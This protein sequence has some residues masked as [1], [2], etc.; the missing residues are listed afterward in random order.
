[1]QNDELEFSTTKS[2]CTAS[3]DK[4]GLAIQTR[5]EKYSIPYHRR[6]K[7]LGAGL[8]A[9]TRRNN[10]ILKAR[11][12]AFRART[13]RFQRLK[14]AKVDTARL[15]RTG[16]CASMTFGQSIMGVATSHLL[17]Q[18]RAAAAAAATTHG[19]CGQNLD[20]ALLL[21]DGS[22][23]GKADPAYA[24]HSGPIG[25]WAMA[26]W[27][28]RLPADAL[29][30]LVAKAK[31]RLGKAKNPWAV[32]TGPGA[33]FIAT[34]ARLE[35]SVQGAFNIV[36]DTGVHLSLRTT[37][38]VVVSRHCDEAVRIWRWRRV[39]AVLPG[40]DLQG[41]VDFSPIWKLL[42][43]NSRNSQWTQDHQAMLASA[44][45]GRQ[46][47]QT[48]CYA[49]GFTEHNRCMLC[50]YSQ[51]AERNCSIEDAIPHSP[52]GNLTHRIWQCSTTKPIRDLQAPQDTLALIHAGRHSHNLVRY[53]RAIFPSLAYTI[54][55]PSEDP[56]FTW[57]LR[58]QGG[59]FLG[60]IYSDGSRLDGHNPMLAR[61]GWAFVVINAEGE[62]IAKAQGV[63]PNWITDIPGTE[64][65]A[66]LQAAMLAEPGCQYRIDCK[67]CVDAIH[68]G[69]SW[70]T[71]G[72]RPL[73]RVFNLI[74]AAIDEC[75]ADA[76]VWLPAH[77]SASDVGI[78]CL[79]DGSVLTSTDREANEAADLL[80]KQA[81][82]GHR[83]PR[84]LRDAVASHQAMV[85][86][87]AEWVGKATFAASN[88]T[89]VPH[90]DSQSSALQ[91][92]KCR[93][94]RCIPKASRKKNVKEAIPPALGGHT[95]KLRLGKWHCD[96]CRRTS[97]THSRLS[98]SICKG[99][100]AERWTTLA[101]SQASSE[102][103]GEGGHRQMLSGS[104]LWCSICGTYAKNSY[105]GLARAC[106]GPFHSS[107][108][109]GGG[110]RQQLQRLLANRHPRSNAPL[111]APSEVGWGSLTTHPNACCTTSSSSSPSTASSSAQ[112]KR[113]QMLM[114]IRAKVKASTPAKKRI[115]VKTKDPSWQ[116]SGQQSLG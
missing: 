66:I 67:P 15:L 46:W 110:R 36:T 77:T 79:G 116:P 95:L 16:A 100:P 98:S 60:T 55:P 38:P 20:L 8:G 57:V 90:K 11:L 10:I 1:M 24:A 102:N 83:V 82:N 23:T 12:R 61:N 49:A 9:G 94:D 85:V 4:L 27:D 44:I 84:Q 105:K 111:Q 51:A 104:I 72:G 114:R 74:F 59:T 35:W 75:P 112:A 64:A 3:N 17:A 78:K 106:P 70:A 97:A 22:P 26:V 89:S 28:Q 88:W 99:T 101:V 71:A 32:C 31:F 52:I 53:E 115:W 30:A 33:A 96:V 81:A 13:P 68:W 109:A 34:A 25:Q 93:R 56:T 48:R 7:S 69:K 107:W 62:I 37:P 21:A 63:P 40:L 86:S 103:A 54:P 41:S 45:A 87:V 91:A 43:P 39:N 2:L 47:A 14:R 5:L 108:A 29:L 113:D 19:T 42:K 80:A 50:L 6:V 58:P 65:W 18:R 92:A 76:F 73:A